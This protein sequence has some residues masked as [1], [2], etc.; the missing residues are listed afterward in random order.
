[1]LRISSTLTFGS[2]VG[3]CARISLSASMSRNPYRLSRAAF[4]SSPMLVAA[5]S[6][7]RMAHEASPNW[8]RAFSAAIRIETSLDFVTFMTTGKAVLSPRSP[9]AVSN[10]TCPVTGRFGSSFT[11]ASVNSLPCICLIIVIATA[12]IWGSPLLRIPSTVSMASFCACSEAAKQI[13]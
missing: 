2:A 13:E 7:S 9:S 4:C 3:I 1:M 6:A 5:I 10:W 8:P 11:N 12:C